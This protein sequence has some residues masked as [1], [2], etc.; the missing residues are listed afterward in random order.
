[1]KLISFAMDKFVSLRLEGCEREI[2]F[3]QTK[4]EVYRYLMDFTYHQDEPLLL[5]RLYSEMIYIADDA[6][7]TQNAEL[8]FQKTKNSIKKIEMIV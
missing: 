8:A 3:L 2:A 6:R 1:M 4:L 5:D 7:F